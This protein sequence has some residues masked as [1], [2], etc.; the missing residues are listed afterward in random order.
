MR[1][2]ADFRKPRLIR[3]AGFVGYRLLRD[4]CPVIVPAVAD[5][6][7]RYAAGKRWLKRAA[8]LL[9]VIL[10]AVSAGI[11]ALT[12]HYRRIV[13][14]RPGQL[15]TGVQPGELGKWVD[16][17]IATG[18]IPWVCGHNFPGA[19]V[20][21]GAVRLG[22]DTISTLLNK[23][24]LNTSGYYYADDHLLGFSHTRLIGTGATDGGA[25]LVIPALT[26]ASA[27]T[28]RKP[29][30]IHFSHHDESASPGYYAV[31][32]AHPKVLVELTASP[33]VGLHRYRF[34]AKTT[35][36][37]YFDLMNALG[38]RPSDQAKLKILPEAR[39]LEG[40]VR[41]FG[42]FASRYGG[43]KT[44]FVAQANRPFTQVTLWQDDHARTNQH[45]AT[46][47]CLG[48]D[49]EFPADS[50]QPL[51]LMVG[52][53]FVSIDGA[54][55][56]LEAE[57][58]HR[59]F[60][61][62]LATA[63]AAWEEKL[64]RIRIEGGTET[65][66]TIFYTALY[67]AF[68]MPTVFNDVNGQYIGLDHQPHQTTDFRYFTDLSLWDTFRTVHPLY[69]LIAA[70]DQRDMLVSLVKM[71]E[72]GGWLPRWPCG[73]GYCNSML[74]TPA[75]VVIA[76]SF[77]KGVTNFPVEQAFQ[78]M[79]QTALGP[80][81]PS[82]PFPGR[83][84]IESYLQYHYCPTDRMPKAVSSTLEYAWADRAI[85]NLAVALGHTEDARRFHE[86]SC[87]Y[88]NLWNPETQYFQPR[89]TA[90]RFSH[91][92]KPLLLSYFDSKGKFTKDYVEGSAL[93]W[94]WAAFFDAPAL[95]ALFSDRSYFVDELNRFFAQSTPVRAAW[96]PGPY[97]WHGN[98]PDIH[99]AYLF[100][101]AGRPDL[102]QKWVRW[103][104]EHKYADAHDGLDGNDDAGTLSAWYVFS[105]LGF[106]PIAGTDR[107]E[108]GAPLF[109][110][111]RL[112][113]AGKSLEILAEPFA[114]DCIYAKEV[115]LNGVPLHRTWLRHEEL[116]SGGVLRFEMSS[117]PKAVETQ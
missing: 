42:T 11:G 25:F 64:A 67:R 102:T 109:P 58:A 23:R 15:N 97:Y 2:P 38:G 110:R 43:L 56:N 88:T 28:F 13:E 94:R 31:R 47:G 41:S 82:A 104:L 73:H 116:V 17:F 103:I 40:A 68:Q 106:Y 90:G 30:P 89:D 105:A 50:H 49:L 101:V 93:Q 76:D 95:I 52:L 63:Q 39:Q 79:R 112:R 44:Y 45:A 85:A 55:A 75:D 24:A 70:Q 27:D 3:G 35:P 100:N 61:E 9:L 6:A 77:L 20:P 32:L 34:D 108:L 46:G 62:V 87:Y 96:N 7:P 92:F 117:Q 8:W 29:A 72:Q 84:G 98:E 48:V 91:P 22:P 113:L 83:Q 60:D 10:L 53:S 36:H 37:L 66:K 21:F 5:Q 54:R 99:A 65:Q 14:A 57:T 71:Q 86:H 12:L 115:S 74:G 18:G 4:E 51:I 1:P 69:T 26:P 59:S 19:S 16:P 111:A 33:H 107:Y 78:A 114:P 81:P 80:T